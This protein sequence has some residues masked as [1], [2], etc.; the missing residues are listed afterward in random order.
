MMTEK[1]QNIK[2]LRYC[3]PETKIINAEKVMKE[4]NCDVLSII[5]KNQN[6]HGIITHQDIFKFFENKNEN[7]HK[8]TRVK[9]IIPLKIA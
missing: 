9:E 1:K 7:N 3:S 4:F 2:N 8:L 6:N 5:D